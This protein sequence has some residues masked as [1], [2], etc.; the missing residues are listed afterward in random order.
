[1][2]NTFSKEIARVTTRRQIVLLWVGGFMV[3]PVFWGL[4]NWYLGLWTV[5]EMLAVT[6]SP[7]LLCY[8]VGYIGLTLVFLRNR[9]QAIET[10]AR[11]PEAAALQRAQRAAA[12]L[13]KAFLGFITIYCIIGP[14]TGM[15]GKT[16]LT[17]T[18]YLLGELLGIPFILLFAVPFFL[19]LT[20]QWERWTAIVPLST[21]Y[22]ALQLRGKIFCSA[23]LVLTGGVMLMLLTAY[24]CLYTAASVAAGLDNL[25]RKGIPI[26]LVIAATAAIVI[27]LLTRQIGSATQLAVATLEDIVNGNVTAEFPICT[28]DEIGSVLF[29]LKRM[30]GK[31]REISTEM[32]RLTQAVHAGKLDARGNIEN[33]Q[34]SW[35]DL[36]AGVNNVIE[37]FVV[38][39]HETAAYL[40]RIAQGDIP[41]KLT[42]AAQGDF[43]EIK[44]NLNRLIDNLSEVLN[45]TDGLIQ[46]VQAGK[47]DARGH[48]APFAGS[49]RYLILGVNNVLDAFMA[50]FHVTAAYLD[51]IAKGELPDAITETYEGDF[52]ELKHNL[53][54]LLA[55]LHA[56]TQ[57]AEEMAAGNLTVNVTE[58]S[59]QDRLMQALNAMLRRLHAVVSQVKTAAAQVS[60]GSQGM[61]S[62][63]EEMSQGAAEQAS[64]S[65]EASAAMEQ[66][67]AN[68][69]Q[70]AD[71]AL[72]TEKIA[73]QAAADAQAS[74]QAVAQTVTAMKAI[75]KRM[76]VIEEIARQTTMLS[77]NAT[78]EAAKAQEYGKGFAVVAAE[79]RALATRAQ[80]AAADINQVA[81]E[82]I[83]VAERAGAMLTELVPAIRKTAALVQEI[84]AANGEQNT[85]AAQIN[86]AMQQLDQVTQQNSAASEE[87]AATAEELTAQAKQLQQAVAFF[88]VAE[89]ETRPARARIPDQPQ[90]AWKA[91][92]PNHR[93]ARPDHFHG[94]SGRAPSEFP[95]PRSSVLPAVSGILKTP[96][97]KQPTL[98][99]RHFPK[100]RA[101]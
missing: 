53:N 12:A 41:D 33:V 90:G 83:A 1:M 24:S 75:I 59:A 35:R 31:L 82:S 6:V 67:V 55:A 9:L 81:A 18:D 30:S 99:A 101:L 93:A 25:V 47:L 62:N 38:P 78:I 60:A 13:P 61:R 97:P 29:A 27:V 98:S 4:G 80:T 22:R 56:I 7:F 26:A 21:R 11:N 77:L 69:R 92:K 72:Q 36:V 45:E 70:T 58:R 15:A 48:A 20:I 14:H 54:T 52:N 57:L 96:F 28:R 40:D 64:A 95:K 16:F 3:P 51:R 73:L 37:A 91:G 79:V 66:M 39:I 19:L 65:E 63:A 89:T 50:P 23:Y 88:N 76:A 2:K 100:C 42:D 8:V 87:L 44:N 46:A 5:R 94:V 43:N 17:A 71:N 85:D 68:L 84:S 34:G 74:G 32:D 49:W 86:R 10:Y